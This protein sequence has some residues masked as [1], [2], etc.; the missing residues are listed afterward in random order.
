MGPDEYQR[1]M[2]RRQIEQRIL[3]INRLND[4]EER[5]NQL[6]ALLQEDQQQQNPRRLIP[7]VQNGAGNCGICLENRQLHQLSC[8]NR[9][10][11]ECLSQ[12]ITT[13]LNN[14]N[15]H[16]Q[17]PHQDC[18]QDIAEGQVRTIIQQNDLN[19]DRYDRL[20]Q[21]NV[22]GAR[23]CSNDNCN[24]ILNNP[25]HIVVPYTCPD[26]DEEYCANCG[27][28]HE[29]DR[30]C[31]YSHLDN[32][33]PNLLNRILHDENET[34]C[35]NCFVPIERQDGC[36]VMTCQQPNCRHV[37]CL[38]CHHNP[39]HHQEGCRNRYFNENG[40]AIIPLWRQNY[41]LPH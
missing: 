14:R 34:L 39:L 29:N 15:T 1:L 9:Y 40:P 19:E 6:L 10:C 33:E 32:L 41:Q 36:P 4:E 28:N 5:K 25:H 18:R 12:H 21:Q 3:A 7:L 2:H 23:E 31:I 38:Y 22:P 26:C 35:P 24:H 13:A 30:P 11:M 17:C 8:G 16:I 37:F 27:I 20:L